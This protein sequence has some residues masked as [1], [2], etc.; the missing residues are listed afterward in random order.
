MESVR[1]LESVWSTEP[2]TLGV[3]ARPV[4][5]DDL[6]AGVS[7]QP[8]GQRPRFA[9]REHID[10]VM[11]FSAGQDGGVGLAPADRE[12]V[13]PQHARSGELR[14]GQRHNPAQQGHPSCVETQL[15]GQPCAG[16]SGQG[17][18][19]ALQGVVEPSGEPRVRGGQLGERLGE[20]AA[21]AVGRAADETPD[22]Q[23]DHDALLAEREINL[24]W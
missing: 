14:I 7:G 10:H 3:G 18:A 13:H 4:P 23:P 21:R 24:R 22:R 17:E 20:H 11:G 8:R 15:G 12:V 1:D 2:G 19:D 9:C 6:H 5:A 16:A